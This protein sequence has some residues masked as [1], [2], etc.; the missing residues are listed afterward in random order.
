MLMILVRILGTGPRVQSR[1]NPVP[2]SLT[3]QITNPNI[4]SASLSVQNGQLSAFAD[5]FAMKFMTKSSEEYSRNAAALIFY[6]P[7]EIKVVM[8]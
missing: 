8:R 3:W 2:V 4:I 7:V 5:T 1:P 6:K